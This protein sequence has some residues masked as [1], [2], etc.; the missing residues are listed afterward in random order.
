MNSPS[1]LI[2][3]LF[4]YLFFEGDWMTYVDPSNLILRERTTL[5]SLGYR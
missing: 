1:L 3:S 2:Q 5:K 4:T